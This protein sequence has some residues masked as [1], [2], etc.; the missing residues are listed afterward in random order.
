MILHLWNLRYNPQCFSLATCW[1][2]R[3]ICQART[4][5]NSYFLLMLLFVNCYLEILGCFLLIV[6]I[7][8]FRL[9][10]SG[11]TDRR[12]KKTR[13]WTIISTKNF[14]RN[15]SIDVNCMP[16]MSRSTTLYWLGV[17]KLHFCHVK[18]KVISIFKTSILGSLVITP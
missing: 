15:P 1:K 17:I 12:W 8:L 14:V 9:N 7:L 2:W 6:I 3:V 18:S 13:I 5:H 16:K 10:Y 4:C 11:N